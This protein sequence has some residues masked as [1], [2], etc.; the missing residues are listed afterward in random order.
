MNNIDTII[1]TPERINE[2][3]CSSGAITGESIWE[4]I[5]HYVRNAITDRFIAIDNVLERETLEFKNSLVKTLYH[6]LRQLSVE[7]DEP[8]SEE[9]CDMVEWLKT[10]IDGI[11]S[12]NDQY[13]QIRKGF[14][15]LYRFEFNTRAQL[16]QEVRRQMYIINPICTEYAKPSYTFPS[17]DCGNA[18]HFYLTSRMSVI[19]DEL[20]YHLAKLYR[21]PNLAFYAAAE[22]FYDRLAFASD[23]SGDS[24]ISM[25]DVWGSFFQE[26]SSKLWKEDTERYDVVNQLI[27]NYHQLQASLKEFLDSTQA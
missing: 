7:G 16:I 2:L 19:E 14:N 12:S 9:E 4:M 15:F 6:E 18:V 5:L 10:M 13:I 17:M 8:A 23:L 20:R 25:A 26:Y 22:E 27:G 11:L 24:M 21:T 3:A 1:P